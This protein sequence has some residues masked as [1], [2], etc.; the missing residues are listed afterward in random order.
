VSGPGLT[1]ASPGDAA[2]AV[3]E[4]IEHL[5]SLMME[6]ETILQ[7]VVLNDSMII[8]A[9]AQML[10][11]QQTMESRHTRDVGDLIEEVRGMRIDLARAA[12]PRQAPARL[13]TEIAAEPEV[14]LLAHLQP[15][16]P[17]RIAIDVG[18]NV[19]DIAGQLIE[20]GY[21]V[22]AFEPF[23]G[24]FATLQARAASLPG[25]HAFQLAVSKADDVGTLHV[26]VDGS[27]AKKWNASLFHSLVPH[28]M[29]DDLRF[30]QTEAV[31][32][33]SL[34]SLAAEGAVPT[35]VAVLKIDTEGHD[36]AVIDGLGSVHSEV[37]VTEFWDNQHPFGTAGHAELAT[38][39]TQLRGLGYLSHIVIYRVDTEGQL[40]FYCNSRATLPHSWGNAVFFRDHALFGKA[41]AWCDQNLARAL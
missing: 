19:G 35:H 12:G 36:Q 5:T 11:T 16:L 17:N 6:L 8:D 23:G 13:S 25:L 20:A 28:P 29:L 38:A 22:F 39:V 41:V 32:I 27:D 31:Q 15:Y 40:G 7:S 33:R 30:N 34:A 3:L 37:I 24:S 4:R 10:A 2:T 14:A 21:E 9:L 1:A 26:A 18:A